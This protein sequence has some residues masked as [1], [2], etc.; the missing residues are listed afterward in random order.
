[1]STSATHP[2]EGEH[3]TYANGRIDDR[4]L[5]A[6]VAQVLDRW[7]CAGLAVAVITDGGLAWF[8]GHGLADVAAKTPMTEDTV[9]RIGS[10]TKT[11]TAVAV[12]QLWE[13]GLVDLDTPANDYLRTFR[14]VPKK[15]N[16]SP[17]TVRHLLTHTAGVGYLRQLS[18]LLQPGVGSGDRA[19]RSGA[20]PL[21]QY[22]RRGLPWR[23]S[24]E[25]SGFT[26]TTGLPR[27][28]RSSRT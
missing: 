5:K 24:R 8:H 10:I 3:T 7:P 17:A 25:R 2:D 18:D 15:S 14:L 4:N 12:M 22:Y 13:Q 9:F 21:A 20:P 6:T 23:L 19:G 27:S 11:F 26:A 1:M 28:G 16:L